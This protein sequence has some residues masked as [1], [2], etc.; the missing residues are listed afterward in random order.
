MWTMKFQM[1]KLDLGKAEEPEIKL[2]IPLDHRKSKRVPEKHLLLLYSLCH[3][4]HRG[5][6]TNCKKFLKKWEY[7]TAL[8]APWQ[9]YMHFKK[10]QLELEMEQWTGSK[11]GKEYVKAILFPTCLFNFYEEYIIQN[12]G[13]GETQVG[14]KIARRNI[15]NFRYSDDATLMSESEEELKSILMMMKRKMKRLA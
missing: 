9:I 4:I 12:A 8:P 15:N 13:L 10:Q 1:L 3:F 5:I 2:P 7:Q 11:L 6:T 14:I